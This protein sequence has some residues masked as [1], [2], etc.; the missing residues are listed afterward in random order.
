M[1]ADGSNQTRLTN[2]TEH[3]FQPAWSRD[4]TKIAF[5]STRDGDEEIYVMN[6]D[7]TNQVR[8]TN[9]FGYDRDPAF[10]PDGRILFA[11][12]R[13]GELGIYVMNA[14]GSNVTR[15]PNTGP[16]D[17]GPSVSPDGAR[18]AFFGDRVGNLNQEIYVMN[19]D[20]SGQTRLTDNPA[21][22]WDVSWGP[23]SATPTPTPT[24]SGTTISGRVTTPSGLGLRN[25]IVALT[26]S[27][28]VRR[29][30]TTSTFGF[31]SFENVLTGQTYVIGV[32]SKRYRFAAR[33]LL[34]NGI[35]TNVDFIGLE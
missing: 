13:N 5:R 12:A 28:G 15:L 30:A 27:Q 19:A 8:L 17:F 35:L 3:D 21:V 9:S 23:S 20:G 6:S 34:V 7:G 25:A 24:P 29:T 16:G 33:S 2:N 22:D 14:D 1:N 4:G 18:I 11:S 26:D 32:S 10:A 31:F